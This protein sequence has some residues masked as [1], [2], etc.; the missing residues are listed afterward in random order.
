[1]YI[2]SIYSI[3][4][5]YATLLGLAHASFGCGNWQMHLGVAERTDAVD[6]ATGAHFVFC[7][8]YLLDKHCIFLVE[9]NGIVR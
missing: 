2:Y 3:F 9:F 6:C 8:L 7:I 1:M 5:V 4:V